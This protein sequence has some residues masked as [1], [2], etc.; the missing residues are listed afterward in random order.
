MRTMHA[1]HPR[2]MGK[3][4]H[5]FSKNSKVLKEGMLMKMKVMDRL[6]QGEKAWHKR[7]FQIRD[8]FLLWFPAKGPRKKPSGWVRV[9]DVMAVRMCDVSMGLPA[10]DEESVTRTFQVTTT[11]RALYLRARTVE[12]VRR[13][14]GGMLVASALCVLV[15]VDWACVWR[16]GCTG[17]WL[18][19][20]MCD[21]CVMHV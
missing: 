3:R 13:R 14:S 1:H 19:V 21:A 20:C 2:G 11:A 16:A 5:T 7:F 9:R 10:V 17:A 18:T 8:G 15:V 6:H 4:R 12:D